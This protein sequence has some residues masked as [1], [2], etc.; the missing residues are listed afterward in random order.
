MKYILKELLRGP[1]LLDDSRKMETRECSSMEEA[2]KLISEME[3]K[4]F[5]LKARQEKRDYE[6]IA[7]VELYFEKAKTEENKK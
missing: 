2:V 1:K 4:G 3:K 7:W 6:K 5:D